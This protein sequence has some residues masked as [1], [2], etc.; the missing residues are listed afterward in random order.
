M[1]KLLLLAFIALP[2]LLLAQP[3]LT[4][5]PVDGATNV[6]TTNNLTINST[7]GLRTAAGV[8][9]DN[10]NVDALI[11][12]VDG[13]MTPVAFDATV[14]GPRDVITINPTTA[15]AEL[16]TYTLTL[17]PV[18]NN[19]G[20]ETTTQVITFT[21][22]DFTDPVF[23]LSQAIDN[24]GAAFTF[25]VTVNENATVYYI[26]DQSSTA[27][28]RAQVRAGNKSDNTAA[29]QSG[30]F[31]VNAN[32]V[33]SE[34]VSGL[35]FA[36]PV[37]FYVHFF[38]EDASANESAVAS[39][40]IPL[41]NSSSVPVASL[42][43][44]GFD[45]RVNI[46][47][48]VTT[49]YV[50]TQSSTAPT[51]TQILAGQNDTGGAPSTSGNFNV[52]IADTDTDHAITGL[53]DLTTYYVHFVSADGA[54]N[55]TVVQSHTATTTDG[56]P[57]GIVTRNPADD[58]TAVD[59]STTTFTLTFDENISTINTAATTNAHRVRLFEDGVVV[60]TIDRDDAVVGMSGAVSADGT[61]STATITFVYDLLPNKN[62]HIIIGEEVFEDAAGND[63]AGYLTATD[64]NF[65]SSGVTVNNATSNICS[66]SFQSIGNIIISEAS[67]ADFNSGASQTL[68][69]SLDNTS[70]FAIS[71]SGVSVSGTS[72]DITS[73][74]ISVGLSS[75][76]VTYTVAGGTVVDNI[77]ISGLKVYATGVVA[78]ATIIRTGGT[79]D[80]DG[81]NGTAASSLTHATI[82]VGASAPAQPQLEVGQDLIHCV[83]EDLTSKTLTLVDQGV[84]VT[85]NWYSD[86]SLSTLVFSSA[87]ETVNLVADLAMT[88]PAVAGT[89]KFYLVAVSACQS[90]PAVEVTLQVSANPV[91]DAG[92]DRVGASAV[93][94]GTSLTLGGNPTLAVPSAPGAYSY[95]WEYIESTPEPDPVANPSI[96]VSNAS[97][98]SAATFNYQVTITDANGC[99]G[100]DM[101]AVEVKPTFD[102][103][104]ISPNSYT[105]TPNSPNQSLQASPSGGM[106]SGVGVVQSNAPSTYQFSPSIAHA[107]DPNTLPKTFDIYYTVTQNGCTISNHPIATFTIANS[108]FSSLQPQYCGNE[109]PN[110]T[111]GGVVLSLDNTGY[112]HVD[113]RKNNWND[114]ERFSRGPYNNPWQSGALYANGAYVRYNNEIYRCNN[115]LLGC[116]G[117]TAPDSDAQ[118]VFENI[119]KVDFKGLIGNYY[120]DYYGGNAGTSTIAKLNSTYTVGGRTFNHYRFGTNVN[121]NNCSNCSYAWPA[122]YLEF[123]RPEDIRLILPPWFATYYYYR[124]D[125]VYYAGQVYQCTANPYTTGTQPDFNPAVWTVVTNSDYSN[126]QYFHKWDASLGAFRS[127]FYVNGQYVHINRNPTVFFS[128]LANGD[129]VCQF[130]VLNLDN[131]ASSVGITYNLAGNFASQNFAQ[132][133]FVKLDG[134]TVYNDGGGAIVNDVVPGK[135]T[136]DTELAFGVVDGST[137]KN[138]EIMYQVDPGTTGSTSQACYGTSSI[139]IQVLRN[140]TF[141]FDND[142]VDP[143][144]SI[145]C[146]TE[147]AKG[148]RSVFNGS[149]INGAAGSPNSVTYSGDGV[150]NL[151]NS[152]GAFRPGL[153]VDQINAGTSVQQS[154]PVTALYRDN[155]LCRSSRVRT[156]KVNPDIQPSF[157]FGGRANYCYEDVANNFTG[158]FQDFT[159]NGSTVTST[160]RYEFIYTDPAGKIARLDTVHTDNTTF[161]AQTFYEQIQDTLAARNFTTQLNQTVNLNVWYTEIV[162]IP[163][164]VCFESFNQ[165]MVINRPA[166]LDIFGLNENDVLCRNSNADVS[167]GN[168]VT[169]EGSVS[170]S[171]I[172]RLNDSNDFSSLNAT[173]NGTVNSSA[174]KATINL[175]NAYNAAS[176]GTGQRGVYLQ[177]EYTAPGCTGAADVVKGFSISPPPALSFVAPTPNN[178]VVFC[179][180]DPVV[181]LQTN[182]DTNVTLTG[183]GVTDSGSG[184]GSG[185]FDPHLA[186]NTSVSNGGSATSAQNI[187]VTARIIDGFG[188]AN[189]N[190]RQ[191]TVNAIPSGSVDIDPDE[192]NYCYEDAPRLITGT[193]TRSWYR[194]E[195]VS[196][197]PTFTDNIGSSS[198]H[199]RQ[200]TFDPK[201]RFDHA[202][203]LG[204]SA[205]SPVNF[206]VFY[207]IA[208]AQNCTNTLGP[209][210]LAVANQIEVSIAGLEDQQIYCSNEGDGVKVLTFNPF[211]ADASKRT[212]TIN[213]Q[214]TPLNSDKYSFNPGQAGG[215]FELRYSV[216]S[217]NN[218]T[219]T[220][221]TRV[222][223]LPSPVALFAVS[224]ACKDDVIDYNA[225]GTGN[226]ASAIYTWTFSG[227]VK[228]GQ[229]VQHT[230]PSTSSYYAKLKVEHP[231]YQVTPTQSLVC[232]DSLQLDQIVGPY[233]EDIDFTFSNVCEDDETSFAVTSTV[234]I[235]R[236]SW[237]FGDAEITDFGILSENIPTATY[238]KSGGTYQN[239]I[240]RYSGA[241]DQITVRVYGKTSNEFGG[242]ESF[243][244]RVISILERWAP[245][246]GEPL[247][248]MSQIDNGNGGWVVEDQMG[249]STWE[250]NSAAKV[251]INTEE[252]AWVTGAVQPYKANDVSYVN[253][254]CFDL[255]AFTRPVISIK[256]WADTEA[257]DGAVLQ[258]S[259]DG[260]ASWN[261]LGEVASGLEWYN[262]LTIS[263]NPGNQNDLS[264]GWSLSNQETWAVGKHT[265]DVLPA[266]RS[267]VRFRIAFSSFNNREQR[268]GFAFNNVVIQERNRTILVENFTT[269]NTQQATNNAA[270]RNFRAMDGVF[271]T[272]E[273]VKLQYHHASAQNPEELD[274]L[275]QANPTDQNARAAFYGVTNPV[276]AFID[277]GFGQTSTNATF[278]SP[279]LPTYFGL[280]SLVASPV[281]IS[282]EFET[283]PADKLNVKATVQAITDLGGPG[284]YNVFMAVAQRDTL[285]QVY[286]LRKFLPDASGTPLTSLAPTDPAQEIIASYDMRHVTR[287]DNGQFAPFAVIVFV[288]NLQTKDVLQTALLQDG[289]PSPNVVTGI[290]TP[291]DNI[292][293]MYPNPADDVL[294][295]ILPSP[296][297]QETPVR[298]FDN[299]GKEAFSGTFKSGE[300]MKTLSTKGLSAGIYLIQLTTPEGVVR[301]KAIIVHN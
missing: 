86:A 122:A 55:Q 24:T 28:T 1:K 34:S 8:N 133:F 266:Q 30:S 260:G 208:D 42:T 78:S 296:V 227:E 33:T 206:N 155:S 144:G 132:Q 264:S 184:D 62:Y 180:N 229:N 245:G 130:D 238:P 125:L 196:V 127:G 204:A 226:L 148:L 257:S 23:T 54:G 70:E 100:T 2:T 272:A 187:T 83:D 102:I 26:V 175:L 35:D 228:T 129:D 297:K 10:T 134:S 261:R 160:G 293:R 202:T 278:E 268:D 258:Y 40:G 290:E 27:P 141:D 79:A 128:G 68:V 140:S 287:L 107:T 139:V 114:S 115:L 119:L 189:V 135:A 108:F 146:Y 138:V 67:A 280:R 92:A 201:A 4:F 181:Q 190:T 121:Y 299:F 259:T 233:P 60:E 263:S 53:D 279:D 57:P 97:T 58:A 131:A 76:T 247:Y 149:A 243:Q 277:G 162:T 223:A 273:L 218:C 136:L 286:V 224:P 267:Q 101:V 5:T 213:G 271:N 237:D 6:S 36:P 270:Y 89:Y 41:L 90:A 56:T 250:F 203:S 46:D 11:S 22:G 207:T 77:T 98:A 274:A 143:D 209:Y 32:T 182:E 156:F 294:N 126:G 269:L 73:L 82:N 225:D 21:T 284:E 221:T 253:S 210:T 124:G 16:T 61:S 211:P 195:Y 169:F 142:V 113:N 110:A 150:N 15:L 39:R 137:V 200:F 65:S 80:Q 194:I 75:M 252:M 99:V 220:D 25:A 288:Q 212:F 205:L 66:G 166:V 31:P 117:F 214:N 242:C 104:L 262:K 152:L 74:S 276:R 105:F 217:G 9:L 191:Y 236:V 249:N 12:L 230:F 183:F 298:L 94:T 161:T 20:E 198:S 153:A 44:L 282:I 192:L 88:S 7:E 219:N 235:N 64:W 69:L 51:A 84:S 216:I 301:K 289:T 281:Q 222:K 199:Q 103:S 164:K 18:E 85:Y 63:F 151:G 174:G 157:T 292:L 52:T 176:G 95:V 291:F 165:T 19:S 239:P 45:L 29:E 255:T 283:E 13:S 171:G 251:W 254:P 81:N 168:L 3:T 93:C 123:E 186:F 158:H 240:H 248:D 145:Y 234:P 231:P 17:Q 177:Y 159:I 215:D 87:N 14:N 37:K 71:N 59:I 106:F 116:S 275:H 173:L 265:L 246:A 49:Y 232:L 43:P 111:T 120:E 72:A 295:I 178:A 91:A 38:A 48:P 241:N 109:Y 167:Q 96:T 285:G 179:N 197:T 154:V 118:W 170:G 244:Q 163:D 256:H 50:V 300:H 47:E 185:T 147:P 112:T 193:Q 172:F 188:C